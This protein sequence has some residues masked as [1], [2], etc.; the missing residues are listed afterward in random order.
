MQL[1]ESRYKI[2]LESVGAS[3]AWTDWKGVKYAY[4]IMC[5]NGHIIRRNAFD[6]MYHSSGIC[7]IPGNDYW[8]IFYIV[9]NPTLK[10]VKFGITSTIT[11]NGYRL[12]SH[13]INGYTKLLYYVKNINARQLESGIIS[14]LFDRGYMPIKGREYFSLDVLSFILSELTTYGLSSEIEI[15]DIKEL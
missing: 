6:V 4:N 5:P 10:V 2:L 9:Y 11:R 15:P 14:S 8:D 1:S 13:E 12:R 7:C 3:P